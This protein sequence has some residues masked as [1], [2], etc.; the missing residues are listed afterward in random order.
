M[1]RDDGLGPV[2]G[3]VT[4]Q[5]AIYLKLRD[6]LLIGRFDPGQVL[7]MASLAQG[8][9]TSL[10]PVREALRRLA[11]ENALEI[12][13]NGSARVPPVN[14]ARLSDLMRAR[15]A[16]EGL[17]AELAAQQASADNL[18]ALKA[19]IAVHE[20]AAAGGSVGDML[21]ANRAFH[22]LLYRAAGSDVLFQLIDTLW[23]RL[24][25]YMRLLSVH[26]E[27]LMR[28]AEPQAYTRHH[29]RILAA[30]TERDA[31]RAREAL[32]ADIRGT[33]DILRKIIATST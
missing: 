28:E 17:A 15:V 11:A 24:G 12:A 3:R 25:P 23:L 16:V 29:H 9:E 4:V 8:F 14:L 30:L 31:G 33:E 1:T 2:S 19:N 18:A 32:V 27:P 13:R 22:F 21:D 6:A 20:A 26:V 7:T 5:D 10:M